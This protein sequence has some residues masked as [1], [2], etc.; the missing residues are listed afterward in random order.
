MSHKETKKRDVDENLNQYLA[1]SIEKE[2]R[3][4]AT[5]SPAGSEFLK[6]LKSITRFKMPDE[7]E[8]ILPVAGDVSAG[9]SS[10]LNALCKYPILPAA[11]QTTSI[12]AVEIRRTAARDDERIEVCLLTED[13]TSLEKQP[14]KVLRR[15][16]LDHDMFG[17]LQDYA[18]RLKEKNLLSVSD[19][20]DFFKDT[21]GNL[22]LDAGNW[23]HTM[24][25]FMLLLDTYVQQ[26]KHNNEKLSADFRD[27][28]TERN[29]LLN[30]LGIPTNKDYGIRLY[31]DSDLIP[32]KTVIVDLPGTGSASSDADGQLGHTKLV[33]NYTAHAPS[34]LFL[35]KNTG[36]IEK[37]AQNVLD[38]F[39]TAN[40]LKVNSSTRITFVMNK[41]D[42]LG[43]DNNIETTINSFRTNY[44]NHY[45]SYASYPVYCI[46]ARSGEWL[47]RE[48]GIPLENMHI[49]VSYINGRLEDDGI[50]PAAEQVKNKLER[51]YDRAYPFQ[52]KA[53]ETF[54][55]MNLHCFL[56]DFFINCA[57]HIRVLNTLENLKKHMN[58]LE[59]IAAVVDQEYMLL[60]TARDFGSE[61]AEAISEA[62][63]DAMDSAID[64]LDAKYTK[65]SSDMSKQ[66]QKSVSELA[67][68]RSQFGS[69]Y[70]NL[71]KS[72]NAKLQAVVAGMGKNKN[73]TIPIDGNI[74]GTN[75]SGIKNLQKI[76]DFADTIAKMD[77][78]PFFKQGFCK[79]KDEFDR[80]NKL[81]DG[82]IDKVVKTL[83]EFPEDTVK[84]MERKFH[85]V[86]SDK[87]IQ[88]INTFD[89][90]FDM[91]KKATRRLLERVCKNYADNLQD[92]ST[93]RDTINNTSDRIQT[94]FLEILAPYKNSNYAD[95][96]LA[97]IT[98]YYFFK[99]NTIN[100][101]SL[102]KVLTEYY[103]TDFENALEKTLNR[104]ILGERTT[105]GAH[106][107]R[108]MNAVNFVKKNHMSSKSTE[109]LKTQVVN[110][111]DITDVNLSNPNLF[112]DWEKTLLAAV[113]YLQTF[114]NADSAYNALSDAV[115]E[116]GDS[117]WAKSD[118]EHTKRHA[119]AARSAVVAL[120]ARS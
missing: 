118:L 6:S 114:F 81:Y 24:F 85:E 58:S 13:K 94:D 35:I 96:I 3:F 91:S 67:D 109:E 77:F 33:A 84:I 39:L 108:M 55:R 103:L 22:S 64:E 17:S 32:E 65:L 49:A 100:V 5:Y 63:M 60:D 44:L 52:L 20:L 27:A 2:N 21:S 95:N 43:D 10:F 75:D 61:C 14:V 53:D 80:E 9:K 113:T 62:I 79:L 15:Q 51:M 19:T 112:S 104:D 89:T 47:F 31:W 40:E 90:A 68:V 36:L 92:D 106:V 69:D 50:M 76:R 56:Q 107:M 71:S 86:L 83:A 48:S 98:N 110:A 120:L 117:E 73:G 93:V 59:T 18:L 88:D 42:K 26:D 102:N 1:Q 97:R 72:I 66:L 8:V 115:A 12:C 25:L 99:A 87:K 74:M 119:D 23:R 34:L 41:A 45:P 11:P 4:I 16:Q 7:Q 54:G 101:N 29:A 70:K 105:E 82:E 38:T 46:S 78:L 57:E 28:I 111:C 37:E 30:R 116:L